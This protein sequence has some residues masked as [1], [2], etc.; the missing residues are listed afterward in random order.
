MVYIEAVEQ[1]L[2]ILE[3]AIFNIASIVLTILGSAA[4]M[5]ALLRESS[6]MKSSSFY[7]QHC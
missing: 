1:Q 7:R 5:S 4:I 6:S 2:I 3:V